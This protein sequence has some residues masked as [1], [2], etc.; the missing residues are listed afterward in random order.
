MK[1]IPVDNP[2]SWTHGLLQYLEHC[3]SC[4]TKTNTSVYRR[5]DDNGNWSDIWS[6]YKCHS[7]NS[8]YLSPRPDI[9][10]LP[11]AYQ[12]YYT[13]SVSEN[14]Q[15]LL[16][17][18]L[19]NRLINGYLN[20]RFTMKRENSYKLG[21]WLFKI[22]RPLQ[23]KLDIY[24]RNIPKS[25]CNSEKK[26]LD[27]GCG[28]GDFL[29]RS[30][31]MGLQAYGLETDPVAVKNLEKIG[32]HTHLGDLS[33]AN[34][35][36]KTFDYITLNHVIEHVENPEQLLTSIKHILKEDGTIWL[37]LPNPN[38][39]SII[40]FKQAWKGFHPPFHLFIPSQNILKKM[41]EDAGFIDIKFIPQGLQSRGLWSESKKISSQ[42]NIQFSKIS[43]I[44]FFILINI[45]SC[46]STRYSEEIIVTAKRPRDS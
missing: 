32:I 8:I 24:G 4:R 42:E 7:C 19:K 34:F 13:H 22:L 16:N 46:F 26:I 21:F 14:H 33:S 43:S 25:L 18:S 37:A 5:K 30:K 12:N 20:E 29:Q 38:A 39:L 10:S 41:L 35:T 27:I 40:F 31:E 17:S 2:I 6:L 11:K 3:P 44:V 45:I 36:N 1:I 15:D 9:K 23:M 28:N